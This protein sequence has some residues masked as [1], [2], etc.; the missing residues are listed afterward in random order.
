MQRIAPACA[1]IRACALDGAGM[2]PS[3]RVRCARVVRRCAAGGPSRARLCAGFVDGA[4]N[5]NHCPL[6]FSKIGTKEACAGA[7]TALG[8]NY[9]GRVTVASYPSGCYSYGLYLA[10]FNEH[11]TGAPNPHYAPLCA[12]KA[13]A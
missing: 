12:G 3:T 10:Y 7:A 1:S 9:G 11:P 4:D 5:T 8:R 2:A 6:G 13:A